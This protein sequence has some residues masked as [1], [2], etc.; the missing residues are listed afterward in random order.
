MV[1][2]YIRGAYPPQEGMMALNRKH[3][4]QHCPGAGRGFVVWR[5][6]GGRE[7]RGYLL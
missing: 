5:E 1:D 7:G 3:L 6:G 4:I 2:V